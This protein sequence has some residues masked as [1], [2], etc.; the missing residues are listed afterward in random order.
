MEGRYLRRGSV[1]GYRL[2]RSARE[3]QISRAVLINYDV[4]NRQRRRLG[5]LFVKGRQCSVYGSQR[6]V[7]LVH[8]SAVAAIFVRPSSLR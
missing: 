2:A 4:W 8:S 3:K 6:A 5:S 7:V 1:K